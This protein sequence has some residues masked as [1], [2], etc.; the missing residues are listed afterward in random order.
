MNSPRG[1]PLIR[2]TKDIIQRAHP[3]TPTL[4]VE[5]Y[6]KWY[7][8]FL[9]YPNG[10]IQE[11][12]FPYDETCPKGEVPFVDHVPNPNAV[13]A[14]ADANEYLIDN[15]ALEMIVGRWEIEIRENYF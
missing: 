2:S 8:L 13:I 14:Y 4:T 3:Q 9:V 15:L 6:S 1:L 5:L 11:M 7:G 12:P 10:E